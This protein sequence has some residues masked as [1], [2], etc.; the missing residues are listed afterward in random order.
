MVSCQS[1]LASHRV[2]HL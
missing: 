1:L 2:S